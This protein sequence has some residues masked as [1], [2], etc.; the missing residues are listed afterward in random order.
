MAHIQIWRSKPA[1]RKMT[2]R[3]RQAIMASLISQLRTELPYGTQNEDGPFVIHGKDEWLIVWT[4][5]SNRSV[6]DWK[7][8]PLLLADHFEAMMT[9]SANDKRT[10]RTLAKKLSP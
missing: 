7:D 6:S 3:E 8:R 2:S 10:A 1:W 5:S 4:D 9:V